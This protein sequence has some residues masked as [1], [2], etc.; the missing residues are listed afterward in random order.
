MRLLVREGRAFVVSAPKGDGL[1][2]IAENRKARHDYHIEKTIEAGMQLTG[3]EVKSLREGR[4]QLVDAYASIERGE[5]FLYKANIAEYKQGG[6]YFNHPPVRKRKLL[7]HKREIRNLA[8]IIETEGMTLVP[9]KM[10]FKAGKAKIELGI[11][12]G[13]NKGDKRQSIKA[14]D[15]KMDIAKARRRGR[16]D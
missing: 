15:A 1:K 13:K 9:T 11:A 12:K 16:G 6:P 2:I 10:Y 7:L 3:S 14:R 5:M 4:V 8:A